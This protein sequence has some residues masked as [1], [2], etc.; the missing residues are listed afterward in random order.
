MTMLDEVK[1]IKPPSKPKP[2]DELLGVRIPA[3]LKRAL[4]RA[5]IADER[6]LSGLVQK[7]L[8]EWA[9]ARKYLK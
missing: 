2:K 6:S 8:L 3:E 9:K 1:M 7:I 4:E 5:A